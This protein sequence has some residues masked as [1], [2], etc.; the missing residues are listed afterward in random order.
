MNKRLNAI[1]TAVAIAMLSG[2][3][4]VAWASCGGTEGLVSSAAGSVASKL[5][6]HLAAA[7][8]QIVT[9]DQQQT[10]AMMASIKLLTK[11]VE[12]SGEK[13]AG[14]VLQTQQSVAAFTKELADK[15]LV[16]KIMLDYMSQ[17]YN[18]CEQSSAT[19]KVAIAER[20][21]KASVP[22]RIRSEVDAG[23]GKYA[24]VADALRAREDQHRELF[25][26]QDEV[27][28]GVCSSLGK[29]PGGDTNAALIYSSDTSKDAV[30][31]KNAVINNI[32][33][34]PDS[35]VPKEAAGSPEAAAYVLAKKRKDAFLS[36]SAYSLKSIQSDAE[37]FKKPMDERVGMFFGTP[38][39][40]KWAA[41][42]AG[43]NQRG[44]LVDMV[45]IKG[46]TLK[47]AERRLNQNLRMEA[48]LAAM[49]ELDNQR[50]N[51]GATR[52]AQQQIL[53]EQS[54]VK[55]TQ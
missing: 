22:S 41:S 50:Y 55:V 46:L 32:I 30:A 26:T 21:A 47:L 5:V 44:I 8:T 48:N 29:I 6:A 24:S 28:A 25:C 38:E 19:Y 54:R 51:S 37:V 13:S 17:G 15:E 43:Q 35:P 4:G 27:D 2:S 7:T 14:S 10:E 18:P 1:K 40:T 31:A 39:A 16:D 36:W 12:M 52:S 49:L 33:G 20:D 42:Q 45:K 53:A 3:A 9:L 23:S 11:Q 34:L